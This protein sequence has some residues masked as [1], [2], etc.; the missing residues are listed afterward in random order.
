MTLPTL[1]ILVD[2]PASPALTTLVDSLAGWC[3][4]IAWTGGSAPPAAWIL[5]SPGVPAP[6]D[7]PR[8]VWVES[9]A[10]AEA[11]SDA[12]V[13]LSDD[14]DLVATLG[15][16]AVRCGGTL[17]LGE[18]VALTPFVRARYRWA[19]GLP[20]TFIVAA[21][22]ESIRQLPDG[23]PVPPHLGNTALALAS[24]AAAFGDPLVAALSW[25]TPCVTDSA[26]AASI[27]AV[28]GVHVVVAEPGDAAY[29][30]AADLASDPRRAAA[31]SRASRRLVEARFDRATSARRVA[32]ALG[33][34][35]R[36]AVERADAA[37]DELATP[38][39]ARVRSRIRGAVSS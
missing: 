7:A 38:A 13:V 15:A 12:A 39:A 30:A 36:S 33:L 28:D 11:A 20:S 9:T 16:V 14:D 27:G 24:A 32:T 26:T 10:D 37:L 3:R 31:L 22:E 1:G 17:D 6:T 29:A 2:G 35:G 23:T 19:R 5:A 25:G 34:R 4:P 21:D 8:A 18:V